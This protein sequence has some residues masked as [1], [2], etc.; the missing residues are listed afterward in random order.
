MRNPDGNPA[1]YP[2]E[3]LFLK[4]AGIIAT[5]FYYCISGFIHLSFGI[6]NL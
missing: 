2:V 6:V 3:N 1:S 5:I 4:V